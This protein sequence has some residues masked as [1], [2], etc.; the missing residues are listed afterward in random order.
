MKNQVYSSHTAQDNFF[1]GSFFSNMA[2]PE[3]VPSDDSEA[4]SKAQEGC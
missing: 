4:F 1:S 2:I 3:P